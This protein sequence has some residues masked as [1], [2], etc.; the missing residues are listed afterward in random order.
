MALK[1]NHPD[2]DPKKEVL[3]LLGGEG[4]LAKDISMT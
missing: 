2:Y 4:M 3:M 1:H